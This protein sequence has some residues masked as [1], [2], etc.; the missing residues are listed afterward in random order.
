MGL[1]IHYSGN[2][3]SREMIDSLIEEVSD[4]SKTLGWQSHAFNDEDIKGGSFATEK[5][6]PV[7]LTFNPDG[8]ILSPFNI[9][10][11]TFMMM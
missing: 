9:I 4:I 11:K 6:E 5:S 2:I 3:I 1:S 8:R 7:F 10:V